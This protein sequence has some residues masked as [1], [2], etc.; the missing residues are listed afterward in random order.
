MSD[1]RSITRSS[2]NVFADAGLP[3]ADGQLVKGRRLVSRLDDIVRERGLN[4]REAARIVDFGQPT[5]L[6][7]RAAAFGAT[8][9]GRLMQDSIDACKN[10]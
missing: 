5:S 6:S 1:D 7:S 2:G 4:Q 10:Y 3:D 8:R 9:V